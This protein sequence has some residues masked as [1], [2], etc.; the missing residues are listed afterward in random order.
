MVEWTVA[1][2]L[3]VTV[4]VGP[5]AETAKDRMLD[6]MRKVTVTISATSRPRPETSGGGAAGVEMGMRRAGAFTALDNYA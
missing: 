2:P 1:G 3:L 5:S 4:S 6:T